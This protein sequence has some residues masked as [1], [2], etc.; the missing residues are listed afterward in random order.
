M[1]MLLKYIAVS[2]A[3]LHEYAELVAQLRHLQMQG[4]RY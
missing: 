1:T 3:V 2:I 4:E